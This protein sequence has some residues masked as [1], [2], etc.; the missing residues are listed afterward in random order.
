ML[1]WQQGWVLQREEKDTSLP[2]DVPSMP[3]P[4]LGELLQFHVAGA[5][6]QW[7]TPGMGVPPSQLESHVNGKC[8]G[9]RG[10]S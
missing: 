7:S 6:Q 4:R 2:L 3:E 8:V 5:H 10:P 1:R 9:C